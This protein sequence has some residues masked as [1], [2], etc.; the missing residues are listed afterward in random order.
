MANKP[1]IKVDGV[2]FDK[3]GTLFDFHATWS[4]WAADAIRE[5]A[6]G[7]AAAMSKVADVMN[8]DLAANSFR[9]T[10]PVIASTNREVAECMAQALPDR[11]VD[12]IEEYLMVTASQAPLAPAVPLVPYLS[13]LAAQGLVLGLMTNDAEF[14]A[15]AHLRSEGIEGLFDFIAGFDSGH[16]AKPAPDPLLAFARATDLRPERV[17]MVGDST[18]DLM[19]GRAAGMQTI[20]VLTGLADIDELAPYADTVFPDISHI[21][22][23]LAV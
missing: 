13:G 20:G 4:T 21:N 15:R 17:V 11:S 16:G 7:E 23:W 3:D 5:L 19:A 8:Y 2:L 1:A 9:A 22:G 12:Y 14:V 18:H 6:H 10:S